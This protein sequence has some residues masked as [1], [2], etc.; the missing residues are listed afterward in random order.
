MSSERVEVAALKHFCQRLMCAY[1]VDEEQARSVLEN[2]I[3]CDLVGRSNH[4]VLRL[5]IEHT[6]NGTPLPEGLAIDGEGR[7][8]TDPLRVDEGAL[9]P[10]AGGKGFG[11]AL[12]IEILSGVITG[13]GV[14]DGVASMYK[15]MSESGHN[16]HF[17]MALDISRFM[18]MESY[19]ARFEAF[20]AAVKGSGPAG[21]VRLPGE[22]R[23]QN[24]RDNL[25]AGIRLDV[26][27]RDTLAAM[28]QP[29]D[30]AP[31]WP[32]EALAVER[33]P[34]CVLSPATF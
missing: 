27:L 31:P 11:M 20:V 22:V 14:A 29:Y 16:G 3:W 21:S 15:N 2:L 19:H 12:M 5:P 28:A 34:Q 8:I 18:P 1:G 32:N 33:S 7:P 9:L 6:R 23:W 4:G 25:A 17:L 26:R 13:A 30:I 10:F 24:H